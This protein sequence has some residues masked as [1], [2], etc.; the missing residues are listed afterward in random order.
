MTAPVHHQ[1]NVEA[2]YPLSAMQEGILFHRMESNQSAVYW[3]QI[4]L[5]LKRYLDEECFQRACQQ[6]SD[7][8]ES[9]RTAFFRDRPM[10]VVFRSVAIPIIRE[11]SSHL[12][13]EDQSR[14]LNEYL[15][16]DRQRSFR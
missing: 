10:Q 14:R 5:T 3:N 15:I 2:L 12:P 8:H 11:D 1:G 16:R 4:T 7:R 6:V 9:F 13:F